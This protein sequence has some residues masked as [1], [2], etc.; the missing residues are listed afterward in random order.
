MK[1]TVEMGCKSA[2]MSSD[3]E[4]KAETSREAITS[5]RAIVATVDPVIA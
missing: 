3:R 1:T 5:R 4:E 2:S